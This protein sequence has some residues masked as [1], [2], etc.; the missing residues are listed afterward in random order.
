MMTVECT[1]N[2]M[3]DDQGGFRKG[4]GACSPD[5]LIENTRRKIYGE[6]QKSL[7]ALMVW[8]GGWGYNVGGL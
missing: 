4:S 5:L 1:V 8:Y 3:R 2:R 6:T 7:L